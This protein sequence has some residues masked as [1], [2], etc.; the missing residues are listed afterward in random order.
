MRF[1]FC[2]SHFIFTCTHQIAKFNIYF[3]KSKPLFGRVEKKK[4]EIGGGILDGKGNLD[5]LVEKKL[6]G[7]GNWK[8]IWAH[9]FL[10]FLTLGRKVDRKF[11]RQS[12]CG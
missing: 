3:L 10:M 1:T 6:G 12:K 7:N 2:W 4:K 9:L 5:C 8:S 11:D